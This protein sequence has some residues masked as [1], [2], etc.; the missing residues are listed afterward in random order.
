MASEKVSQNSLYW[1]DGLFTSLPLVVV[2]NHPVSGRQKKEKNEEK[3]DGL[4]RDVPD[5]E[6]EMLQENPVLILH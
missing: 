3:E 6:E 1:N 5:E 2:D 4:L